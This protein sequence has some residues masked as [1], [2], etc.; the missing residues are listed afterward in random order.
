[1]WGRNPIIVA[2]QSSFKSWVADV[3]ATLFRQLTSI[4]VGRRLRRAL[5]GH[6]S[7]MVGFGFR[8]LRGCCSVGW[9]L[10]HLAVDTTGCSA[11]WV[12]GT[13]PS[14]SESGGVPP[15]FPAWWSA[16]CT[17][18]ISLFTAFGIH[19]T[20]YWDTIRKGPVQ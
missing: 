19:L 12:G 13:S 9:R 20:S 7:G 8:V 17:S 10:V 11:A 2:H 16:V 18:Y 1:M 4:A 15:L 6:G 5:D 14:R 3:V